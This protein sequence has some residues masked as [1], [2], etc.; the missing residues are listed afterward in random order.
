[1]PWIATLFAAEASP[2]AMI[3]FVALLMLLQLG[4]EWGRATLLCGLLTLPWVLKSFVRA[5]V[6]RMGHLALQLRL[7]EGAIF[8]MLVVLAFSFTGYE[9]RTWYVFASLFVLCMLCAWHELTAR[10]HYEH[11]LRPPLQ[12][13]YNP[14]KMF[15]SQAVCIVTYGIMIVGV[16]F[17]E[18]FYHNRHDVLTQSWS[19]SV[20]VLA[21]LYLLL[22]IYNIFA[23]P[24]TFHSQYAS[25]RAGRHH[26]D[27]S[28]ELSA[29]FRAEVRVLDRIMHKR[30]WFSVFFALVVMLLPQGLMFHTRVL[31][32]IAPRAMGGLGATLQE[33]GLAQGT[34]G[35]M[36]FSVGLVLGSWLSQHVIFRGATSEATLRCRQQAAFIV[37][38]PLSP[39]IYWYLS[40]ELPTSLLAMCGATL[41]AQF[42]FGFGLNACQ[43]F[44]SFF[45]ADR[46]RSTTGYLYIP[47]VAL[48]LLPTMSV[49]GYLSTLLG[50]HHFFA[51]NSLAIPF[52]W[53]AGAA[54]IRLL[55]QKDTLPND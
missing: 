55:R 13:L 31:F 20:Y 25:V 3:T 44:V 6:E 24:G 27:D 48:A 42:L 15:A 43:P 8:V 1:M 46:Y 23:I 37:A 40:Y 49:S 11:M 45:S 16:G 54:G 32:F 34:V 41:V 26:H 2:S 21:G 4:E 47:L 36:A 9:A 12:R 19:M 22:V 33:I 38:L 52:A 17:L 14:T 5:K 50:F 10:Q 28:E 35:V 18:V 29:S 39:L 53:T 30:Q 51:L 7:V